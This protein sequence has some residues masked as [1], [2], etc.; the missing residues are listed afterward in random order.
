MKHFRG[1]KIANA[2]QPLLIEQGDFDGAARVP[3]TGGELLL[4]YRQGVGPDSPRPELSGERRFGQQVDD[5]KA[6]LIPKKQLPSGGASEVQ[7]ESQMIA[8]GRAGHHDQAG[9]SRLDH[10]TT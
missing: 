8:I 1:I 2:G 7:H 6:P 3:K 4:G 10:Q 9:H 5:P